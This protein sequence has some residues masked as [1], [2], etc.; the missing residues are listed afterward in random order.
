MNVGRAF[1]ITKRVFRGL[2]HDRRTIALILIAP[3]L[4][5]FVFG[6]AFSG[7]IENV[8]VIVVDSDEGIVLDTGSTVSLSE[9]VISNI[10][11]ETLNIQYSE[12][13]AE[14]IEQVEDGKAWAAIVFPLHFTRDVM[15]KLQ[16]S[17]FGDDTSVLIKADKS[18][19]NVATAVT[20]SVAD[21]ITET[22]T[23][24]EFGKEAP[25]S[26]VD[27]PVYGEN[28]EFID[29][30]VPGI[31]AFAIFL[32]TTLLTLLSF[33]GERT[34]GT[35]DRLLVSPIRRSE[36]VVGYAMAFSVVGMIQAAIL[37][38]VGT[39]VFKI[40][41]VGNP[42]IAFLIVALLAIVS[43]SLGILLSS[44][45]KREAQAVQFLPLIILPCFLLAGIFWPVEAIPSFI[46]PLSYIIPPTYAVE[47]LRSVLLRG[48]GLGEIWLDI[49][50]L[51]AFAAVFL[52]VSV[53]SLRR[54]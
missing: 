18:N 2:R 39:L 42:F 12:S 34:N 5:M 3:L 33:V 44:A 31:V 6:I 47:A 9:R 46:R 7:D 32:L 13:E 49:V 51:L 45:A 40:T 20:K 30:F 28:A 26:I 19:V 54:G 43:V 24:A 36:I 29:F 21:A 37:L 25:V 14:A 52:A 15:A 17:S 22:M 23:M 10:D 11:K 16:G 35:L 4:A 27:S 53:R 41:I 8:R 38:T 48:W 1:S 50:V